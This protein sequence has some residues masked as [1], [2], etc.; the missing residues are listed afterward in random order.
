MLSFGYDGQNNQTQVTPAGS[1]THTQGY[2]PAGRI[3]TYDAPGSDGPT[4][5][6]T[7]TTT[8]W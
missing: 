3:Q 2:T 4:S 7:A 6:G 1:A 5:P 8:A